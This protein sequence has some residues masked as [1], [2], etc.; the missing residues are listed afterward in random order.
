MRKIPP[1]LSLWLLWILILQTQSIF[2]SKYSQSWSNPSP[3]N[4]FY[5]ISCKNFNIVFKYN[6]FAIQIL[7]TSNQFLFGIK[8]PNC[9]KIVTRGKIKTGNYCWARGCRHASIGNNN[10]KTPV[11]SIK[12]NNLGALTNHVQTV[13]TRDINKLYRTSDEFV[14]KHKKEVWVSSCLINAIDGL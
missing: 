2:H 11:T 4:A 8:C 9:E 3:G 12:I 6:G 13:Q 14:K 10:I 1:S 7:F 5:P